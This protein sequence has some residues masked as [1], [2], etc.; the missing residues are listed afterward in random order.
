MEKH[1][2][3]PQRLTLI[4]DWLKD[5]QADREIGLITIPV[6]FREDII[7]MV[8]ANGEFK[9]ELN[10]NQIHKSFL[11]QRI[12]LNRE[13]AFSL[14]EKFWWEQFHLIQARK[15]YFNDI[16]HKDLDPMDSTD[17]QIREKIKALDMLDYLKELELHLERKMEQS[18]IMMN[19]LSYLLG[20]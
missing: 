15:I 17:F 13:F 7:E 18:G 10:R 4:L 6:K 8:G 11:Y 1:L 14:E 5:H 3:S 20:N 9:K 16:R 19:Q 12:L 2:V